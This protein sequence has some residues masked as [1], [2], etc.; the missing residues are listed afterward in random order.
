MPGKGLSDDTPEI[1]ERFILPRGRQ[2]E[3]FMKIRLRMN[4][5]DW[6]AMVLAF[7]SV[8]VGAAEAVERCRGQRLFLP[9][10]SEVAYGDR[11]A[12]LNLAVT[13]MLRNLDAN[14][15]ITIKKV[16]YIGSSGNIVRPVVSEERGLKPMAAE[17]YVI[18]ESDRAGGASSGFLVEWESSEPVLPPL[19]E[20]VMVNGAYN[21]GMAFVTTAR[22]LAEKP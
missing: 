17:T 20:G 4:L 7:G 8:C 19:V 22:V 12:V 6:C 9:V 3:D 1:T 2:V 16:D 14:Q 21:Q 11:R 15:P 10:Y 13:L 18:R 5:I